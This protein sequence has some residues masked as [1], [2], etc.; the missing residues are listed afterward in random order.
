MRLSLTKL[1]KGM[2]LTVFTLVMIF[3]YIPIL[4]LIIFSFND[5][6]I[7]TGWQGFTFKYYLLLFKNPTIGEAFRNTM[8][9]AGLSTLIST[10]LGILTA[11]G[12]ENK[13]FSG[14]R[15]LIALIY[16][17]LMIPDIL[18]GVSLALLFNF[19]RVNTG[20]FTVLIAHITFCISYTVIVIQSRLEDF[21]HSLVE[22]AQDLGAKPFYIFWK[23]K[24][25]LMMPGIVAAALLAFTLSI[26]DF[27]ITFFTSGRGFDTLP[28]YVEGTIRR[29]TITTINSLSTL[30]I[31]FTL[32][33]VVATKRVRKIIVNSL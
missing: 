10:T 18:M 30:M 28:I 3:L 2:N 8:L 14:R 24:F 1:F 27:I 33:L 23:I 32:F 11:L 13:G 9:I 29:G 5:A 7:I 17:P 4:I 16:T 19:T 6:R 12:L 25:P 15:G 20:M 26:D 21:D 22:A 31:A